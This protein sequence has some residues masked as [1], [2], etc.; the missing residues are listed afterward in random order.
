MPRTNSDE[1]PHLETYRGQMKEVKTKVCD[2]IPSNAGLR[3]GIWHTPG[4]ISET[5][6]RLRSGHKIAVYD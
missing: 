5:I 1:P 2:W 3:F 6:A 4:N